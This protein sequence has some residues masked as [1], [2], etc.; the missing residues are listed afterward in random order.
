MRHVHVLLLQNL[1]LVGH[2]RTHPKSLTGAILCRI[3]EWR[4]A[5]DST[6]CRKQ[7]GLLLGQ[8][9][10]L[11]Q[12][13]A[14]RRWQHTLWSELRAQGYNGVL[15][16][17]ILVLLRL[18]VGYD[19]VELLLLRVLII[20]GTYILLLDSL[21]AALIVVVERVLLQFNHGEALLNGIYNMRLRGDRDVGLCTPC[22]ALPLVLS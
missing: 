21:R 1:R 16:L 14:L 13:L 18:G 15:E 7:H 10:M 22:H 19:L 5:C 2:V 3:D 17:L 6:L 9:D 4:D 11:I 8:L 20:Y 12:V